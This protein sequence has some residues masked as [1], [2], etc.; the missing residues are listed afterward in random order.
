MLTA[1]LALLAQSPLIPPPPQPVEFGAVRWE[2]DFESARVRAERES[3]AL[4]TLF[5]EVPG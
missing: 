1:A 4:F 5:Q 2:R 3:K